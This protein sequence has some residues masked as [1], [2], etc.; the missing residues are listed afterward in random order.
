MEGYDGVAPIWMHGEW[1]GVALIWMQASV[2][3]LDV[4]GVG[5]VWQGRVA[6]ILAMGVGG[7]V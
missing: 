3:G 4:W 5:R 7:E 1:D 2:S 6:L